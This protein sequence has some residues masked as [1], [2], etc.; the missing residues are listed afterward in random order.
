MAL[1]IPLPEAPPGGFFGGARAANAFAQQLN[2]LQKGRAQAK[3]APYTEYSNAL[4]KMAYAN[5]LPYQIQ[6]TI[7]S[8]PMIWQAFKD[9]PEALQAMMNNFAQSIPKGNQA[10]GGIN[11]PPPGQGSGGNLLSMLM[12][13]LSGG[14]QQQNAPQMEQQIPPQTA[15]QNP[16][17][18]M[19]SAPDMGQPSQPP[20]QQTGQYP[21][22]PSIQGGMAGVAGQKTAPFST[23]PYKGGALADIGGQPVS[24]PT[25]STKTSMQS[26]IN[27]AERVAPQLE[28]LSD[29][30]APFLSLKG[31]A[32]NQLDRALNLMDPGGQRKLPGQYARYQSLLKSAPE[33][34]VK[35]YG[36]NPTN[37]A[38]HRM[39]QVIEPYLGETAKQYKSRMLD[40]LNSIKEEQIGIAKKELSGGFNVGA[41]QKRENSTTTREAIKKS[42]DEF[43]SQTIRMRGIDP[44]DN[45]MKTWD[46]PQGKAQMYIENGFKRVG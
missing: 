23:S 14:G 2:E 42:A 27:A 5:M 37:K 18:Q 43:K 22:L 11:M 29:L 35:S 30:A 4:S 13:K 25:E 19:G 31:I 8:N 15:Q 16:F 9:K 12:D 6:S 45:K 36:L 34:L 38:I 41:D 33:S 17:G 44:V 24:I 20:S 3:Y 28:K 10:G 21:L 39:E 32:E 26:S 46:V 40:Q 7:M 1:N